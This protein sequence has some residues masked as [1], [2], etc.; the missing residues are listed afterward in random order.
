MRSPQVNDIDT[1]LRCAYPRYVEQNPTQPSRLT[2]TCVLGSFKLAGE[3]RTGCPQPDAPNLVRLRTRQHCFFAPSATLR[4]FY[5]GPASV[6]GV[7]LSVV[8]FRTAAQHDA[9]NLVH[10]RMYS[11]CTPSH[12]RGMALV[13]MQ[14][15]PDREAFVPPHCVGPRVC[16]LPPIGTAELVAP[17]NSAIMLP[18]SNSRACQLNENNT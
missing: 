18:L 16:L 8:R 2:G 14:A 7:I 1:L 15:L 12:W 10:V 13:D 11:A 9:Y 4:Y 3:A 17:M 5:G 6:A